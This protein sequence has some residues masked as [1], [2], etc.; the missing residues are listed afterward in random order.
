MKKLII[1]CLSLFMTFSLV[2]AGQ[3]NNS[4]FISGAT[5]APSATFSTVANSYSSY[6]SPS[7]TDVN[8]QNLVS[9]AIDHS[10]SVYQ[11]T[12]L[13]YT[14]NLRL[15]LEDASLSTTTQDIA[16]SVQYNPQKVTA[17]KD[18]HVYTFS[19]KVRIVVQILSIIN[20]A[21]G[22]A[23]S[24]PPDIFQVK[25]E[26]NIERYYPFTYASYPS[27]IAITPNTNAGVDYEYAV[28]WSAMT[29]A[30]EYEL[31]YT[32]A[33]TY[34]N[35]WNSF[36]ATGLSYNFRNNST[37]VRVSGTSYT[38]SNIFDKGRLVVRVRGIG[39]N[40]SDWSKQVFGA[41]SIAADS[42]LLTNLSNSSYDMYED[43]SRH[44]ETL[45]WQYSATFA[46]EG[47][48]KEIVSYF[49][50]SLRSRQMVTKSNTNN[51]VIVGESFYDYNGRKAVDALPVPTLDAN[52]AIKYYPSFNKNYSLAAYS[53][54]DF[55]L[56]DPLGNCASPTGP[57]HPSAGASNYYSTLNALNTATSDDRFNAY[58]PIAFD[59][60]LVRT[61]YTPDNTGRIRRQ[62]GV[63]PDHQLGTG[64]ET[65]YFYGKP[66]QFEL[67]R[68]FGSEAGYSRFYKKDMVIDPNGQVSISFKDLAGKVV[69]TALAGAVA[70]P[71]TAL[72][73]QSTSAVSVTADL[74]EKDGHGHSD[75]N[76]INQN[77][78]ALELNTTFL[79][80][81]SGTYAFDYSMSVPSYTNECMNAGVCF[82]CVYNLTIRITDDCGVVRSTRTVRVGPVLNTSCEYPT[83]DYTTTAT[84][85]S[86]T[87]EVGNYHIFKQLTVDES[88]VNHYLEEMMKEENSCF[89]TEEEFIQEEIALVDSTDCSMSC[90]EC[91]A[92]L[93]TRDEFVLKGLGSE[94]DWEL[95]YQNC[96]EP[97]SDLSKCQNFF[98][99]MLS[100][101]S[102]GG[103]YAEWYDT[104][105]GRMN[106]ATFPL[107]VFNENNYLTHTEV[108]LTSYN[109][110]WR[111]PLHYKWGVGYFNENG[112]PATIPVIE[113]SP[114][115]YY[116]PV[117][118]YST[119]PDGNL[120]ARPE[121]LQ[122]E[123]DFMLYWQTSWAQSLVTYH[124]EYCYYEWCEVNDTKLHLERSS[125]AFDNLLISVFYKSEAVT[126]GLYPSP[127]FTDLLD[128]DPY[129]AVGGRG[130]A[131]KN[132]MYRIL[133]SFDY[134]YSNFSIKQLAAFMARRPGYYAT[135]AP[136]SADTTFGGGSDTNV[137][138]QEWIHY[139]MLYL[140]E[141]QKL[142]ERAALEYVKA[143]CNKGVNS[144]IGREE[145]NY[146]DDGLPHTAMTNPDYIC[147]DLRSYLYIT[148][149][150]RFVGKRDVESTTKA[151]TEFALYY[152]TGICPEGIYL[153]T[154]L[155]EVTREGNLLGTFS[156]KDK[157]YFTRDMY[158]KVN[159]GISPSY[160]EYY[161][162]PAITARVLTIT[163]N[164][165]GVGPAACDI[166]L[167]LPTPYIF[168][169]I[170]GFKNIR[171]P[172]ISSNP[173]DFDITALYDH[174]FN[175][176]TPNI[177]IDLYGYSCFQLSGCTFPGVCDPNDLAKDLMRLFNVMIEAPGNDFTSTS[178]ISLD[179]AHTGFIT[180]EIE[181]FLHPLFLP[182]PPIPPTPPSPPDPFDVTALRYRF[183]STSGSFEFYT[184]THLGLINLN[185]TAFDPNTFTLTPGDLDKIIYFSKIEPDPFN[186]RGFYLVAYYD[187]DSDPLTDPRP[188]TIKATFDFDYLMDPG[189]HGGIPLFGNCRP[190]EPPLCKT[191]EHRTRKDLELF[192]SRIVQY[193]PSSTT[194][195]TG[196]SQWTSLLQGQLGVNNFHLSAPE[197]YF[198]SIV[199]EI[200]DKTVPT[201][202]RTVCKLKLYRI[203]PYFNNRYDFAGIQNV[204]SIVVDRN[205][206][207]DGKAY[208]FTILATHSNGVTERIAGYT[209]CLPVKDCDC[210]RPPSGG[211]GSG[212]GGGGG[213]IDCNARYKVF[214]KAVERFNEGGF[215][216]NPIPRITAVFVSEA[217]FDCDC[218]P[219]YVKY[220]MTWNSS[221]GPLKSMDE[222]CSNTI[223]ICK[224]TKF[225]ELSRA[226]AAFKLRHPEFS[227]LTND[228][229][230]GEMCDCIDQYIA[231]LNNYTGTSLPMTPV[232]FEQN[233]GCIDDEDCEQ[234]Y[235]YYRGSVMAFNG[236]PFRNPSGYVVP[237]ETID[238]SDG[239][240]ECLRAYSMYIR[241]QNLNPGDAAPM[242]FSAFK[243]GGYCNITGDTPTV[244]GGGDGGGDTPVI[245]A[246]GGE[247]MQMLMMPTESR[248]S[249]YLENSSIYTPVYYGSD[250]CARRGFESP[251]YD[252]VNRCAEHLIEV[253]KVNGKIRYQKYLEEFKA[254]QT[255]RYM[256]HCLSALTETFDLDYTDRTYHYTLYYYD[257][258]G[259]LIRT[260]PPAGVRL[261]SNAEVSAVVV[262]RTLKRKR[263][264]TDHKL[265]TKYEY[266][267]LNQLIKQSVPDHDMMDRWYVN[268]SNPAA[269]LPTNFIALTSYAVNSKT[270]FVAG[271]LNGFG[272]LY[273]SDD[274]GNNW[275]RV[276]GI[277]TSELMEIQM[278]NSTHGYAVGKDGLM[279]K[280]TDGGASWIIMPGAVGILSQLN[281]LYFRNANEG[282]VVGESGQ[283]WITSDGGDNWTASSASI[284]GSVSSITA[285]NSSDLLISVNNGGAGQ[286]YKSTNFGT[287]WTV[288][289]NYKASDL[290]DI[291]MYTTTGGFAAGKDGV[292]LKTT[293]GGANWTLVNTNVHLNFRR[294]HFRDVNKGMA[295][296]ESSTP[297]GYIYTTSNG[298]VTWTQASALGVYRDFHFY[299]A[300]EGY[301]VGNQNSKGIL[302]ALDANL[303]RVS[304]LKDREDLAINLFAVH[305]L[306]E[307]MGFVAG[308]NGKVFMTVNA[309][310]PYMVWTPVSLGAYA[311]ENIRD[312][313][314]NVSGNGFLITDD[315]DLLK[316]NSGTTTLVSGGSDNYIATADNGSDLFL[317]E[318]NSYGRVVKTPISTLSTSFTTVVTYTSGNN[319][320]TASGKALAPLSSGVVTVGN[321]GWTVSGSTLSENNVDPLEINDVHALLSSS[322]ALAVGKDGSVWR[323]ANA[324][325]N[326]SRTISGTSVDLNTA[327]LGSAGTGLVGG[328]QGVLLALSSGALNIVNSGTTEN[329]LD[330]DYL[331]SSN[332]A[333]S[334]TRGL[335][336]LS[337]NGGTSWSNAGTG[338]LLSIC[339]IQAVSYFASGQLLAVGTNGF[340]F[341]SNGTSA[342]RVTDYALP[343]PADMDFN[344]GRYGSLVG[345]K[346]MILTTESAGSVWKLMPPTVALPL[347]STVRTGEQVILISDNQN[348]IRRSVDKGT[349]F[350]IQH[351]GSQ[352]IRDMA[353][354]DADNGA[355]VGDNGTVLRT[356]NGGTSWTAASLSG[357]V[358][359]HLY[360]VHFAY[361]RGFAAGAGGRII[362]SLNGG[363]NWT[364]QTS[365]TTEDLRKIY[366]HDFHT[367]YVLGTNGTLLKS[368]DKGVTW[369]AKVNYNTNLGSSSSQTFY[370][371]AFNNRFDGFFAGNAYHRRLNDEADL[372]SSFFYYD[373]L[374][375]LVVSENTRQFNKTANVY[376]YN[377]FDAQGRIIETGEISQNGDVRNLY[378]SRQLDETLFTTWMSG[379]NS[380]KEVIQTYY[381][382]PL[383]GLSIPSFIQRN[384]RKRVATVS[385]E[386]VYDG[387]DLTYTNA[388]HYD[389]DVHGNVTKLV[390]DNPA[391]NTYGRR[392]VREDYDYDLVSGN[393]NNFIYQHGQKD[394]WIHKYS[395]DA[396]NRVIEVQTSRDNIIWDVDARYEYYR[397]GPLARTE[398]GDLKV[399]GMD[400]AYTLLGGIKGVN[401]NTLNP[402]E[403]MGKDGGSYAPHQ[404]VARDAFGYTVGY[405]HGDY[406]SVDGLSAGPGHFVPSLSGSGLLASRNNFYNGN[407]TSMTTSIVDPNSY[408]VLPQGRAFQYDQLNR[409]SQ[410]LAFSN[411]SL[412]NN[413][414]LS[415]GVNSAYQENFTYDANGNILTLDR[416]GAPG[417]LSMDLLS[418]K[419]DYFYNHP[420]SGMRSN[421]LY[422][423]DDAV[424]SS[425]TDDIDDQGTFTPHSLA[426]NVNLMNNYRFDETGNLIK[427]LAEEIDNI[428]WTVSG[429]IKKVT[430]VPG[431]TKSD[432]EFV[433]DA[434]GNRVAKIE[435]PKPLNPSTYRTTW[436]LHN[437]MG[438]SIATYEQHISVHNGQ[439]YLIAT[440]KNIYG[441]SRLG[442]Q[443]R[444]DTIYGPEDE[445]DLL[446][447]K[448]RILGTKKYEGTNHLGNVLAVFTD[449]KIPKDINAN[450]IIDYY[451]ADV[452]NSYDYYSFGSPMP[453][454][455]LQAYEVDCYWEASS[456]TTGWVSGGHLGTWTP[457]LGGTATF[458]PLYVRQ[459]IRINTPG[460]GARYYF[461]GVSPA[462][463]SPGVTITYNYSVN[464]TVETIYEGGTIEVFDISGTPMT[465]PQMVPFAGGP[466]NFSL[467]FTDNA[468]GPY[469]VRVTGNT[470]PPGTMITQ[471]LVTN[472][473][474]DPWLAIG[475]AFTMYDALNNRQDVTV[476]NPMDGSQYFFVTPS[477]GEQVT[478]TFMVQA[479]FNNVLVEVIPAGGPAMVVIVPA[480]MMMPI[481]HIYNSF[482]PNCLIRV[483]SQPTS[484]IYPDN[485]YVYNVNVIAQ[486][487][488]TWNDI[489]VTS[490][491]VTLNTQI[492]SLKCDTIW[493]KDYRFGF[494]GMEKDNE[495]KGMGNSL[496]LGARIYDSRL[497]RFFSIDPRIK[498]Y[499]WQSPYSYYKNTPISMI[500]FNG[501]GGEDS[502]NST[503]VESNQP[504]G[505]SAA[506]GKQQSAPSVAGAT[507][508]AVNNTS[509]TAGGTTAN[510]NTQTNNQGEAG[511]ALEN[512]TTCPENTPTQIDNTTPA[513]NSPASTVL[514]SQD[515]YK[516]QPAYLMVEGIGLLGTYSIKGTV[517][518]LQQ[519]N[520]KKII[521]VN[522]SGVIPPA[523]AAAGSVNFSGKAELIVD[524][525]VQKTYSFTPPSGTYFYETGTD[526]MGSTW[527]EMPTSGK[528]E[529]RITG[530]YNF[531]ANDGSGGGT[532]I[533]ATTSET[534]T[535]KVSQ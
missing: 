468:N 308:D 403:D 288:L 31:E 282:V 343:A 246:G 436:Y 311:A 414:F 362:T 368:V 124:P 83:V 243:A 461:T 444:N 379:A 395:Y 492:D 225:A 491:S 475:G 219:E 179:P 132:T 510:A 534:V 10:S 26:I 310:S 242:S 303:L 448:D 513:P 449:K 63:G 344:G 419:Y 440:E 427:D 28:N 265:I 191:A 453:G 408:A 37:R 326:W 364:I 150:K 313:F 89:K 275:F 112:Q 506:Q 283:V 473:Q 7:F 210:V 397:H 59:Y 402:N 93:G 98:R 206:L 483:T 72:N 338:T 136:P 389:Y 274:G 113:V 178:V 381:D 297:G 205:L 393:V 100:D 470:A 229:S 378:I 163:F 239:D 373:K 331:N 425:Y 227:S 529:V 43:V 533:P 418:Y 474:A 493:A 159:G 123:S 383:G 376:S 240:C 518:V 73:T 202:V 531:R 81:E 429:K 233:G 290:T 253:A 285:F 268:A 490:L 42:D 12:K 185:F 374:D 17:F 174:D 317:L 32:W 390:T 517:S 369:A 120:Y 160:T 372:F 53:K 254:N 305:F 271:T 1:A 520:G 226:I 251:Q 351:T 494:N 153:E 56:D 360:S 405:Y 421:R 334:G 129:F 352:I 277:Q 198:D 361:D 204:S 273:R 431:S 236:S 177:E 258:A 522:A 485:I 127:D 82:D 8:I 469:E 168:A 269:A 85:I 396:D 324:G 244:P 438:N 157:P 262:D 23:V 398:V 116:P 134:G 126:L 532:P 237:I 130:A 27:G 44:E 64:H 105:S 190:Q 199:Y 71:T 94:E 412:A 348:R 296:L 423:V 511:P 339:D 30:E 428:E 158:A 299:T 312:I 5:V 48:K 103:Q 525:V 499:S 503:P 391:L 91:V 257:Q 207:I 192:F 147:S 203:D 394:Q 38:I 21:T 51:E 76:R 79:V 62:G 256:E 95:A 280:T 111:N 451:E 128:K 484:M 452:L 195:L 186:T 19:G 212:G 309:T 133:S 222:Y 214:A 380:R 321:T 87:L 13:D 104:L 399:Q 382:K 535:I 137:H 60:P 337:S 209:S 523:A 447:Y 117:T 250:H 458:N 363:A 167:Q 495:M 144:C 270:T 433:Y 197:V 184:S 20:N 388:M 142:Q 96:I 57:L 228:I 182:I 332:V 295:I 193:P 252:V 255:K 80:S 430:R 155:N 446:Q 25:S 481:S 183:N 329:I 336:R 69:A 316:Y 432:L 455:T 34:T 463:P 500:D 318:N 467:A 141:K 39:R 413:E 298:G 460:D 125:E 335:F 107:S 180:S 497:G 41:W 434:M 40:P 278:V 454:R 220:L 11:G 68:L 392:Y 74:L 181:S 241:S 188:L 401:S 304:K 524:G 50:G 350:T 527:F 86:L 114:G 232:Q 345:A 248:E 131:Q 410:S 515:F 509:T 9:V 70:S 445:P 417:N 176:A 386:E 459:E 118:G 15:T 92:A 90:D 375:R 482:G 333:L 77:G 24:N 122:N 486:T 301:A 328:N 327:E 370:T 420:D 173:N 208:A 259:S 67:D 488:V 170:R 347:T 235:E 478:V 151:A 466:Q 154:L 508:N 165:I 357:T 156:L 387:N 172:Q 140:S 512:S 315:G 65:K 514:S 519:D 35:T 365:G 213:G 54:K 504:A 263:I 323:S 238:E 353:F 2:K 457:Y 471:P 75:M 161:Y 422:H 189:Y 162:S 101:M 272:Y 505:V 456:Q 146:F 18:K 266:N 143:N 465:S 320:S 99:M 223:E 47:K 196:I 472:G 216:N 106:T 314:F 416:N 55:D 217:E 476:N 84:P 187:H 261:L 148:K 415:G 462:S 479:G 231:Y 249:I 45:N 437:A 400:Y 102:P 302:A 443:D 110:Y 307:D 218:G 260:V 49:D 33:N 149:T 166:K 234:L 409:L 52:P 211:E 4:N 521:T 300:D 169:N 371:I 164:Q 496:N 119:D 115:V 439:N 293:D 138:N 516:T 6:P 349:S 22:S 121:Q 58:I 407:I 319:P 480:G 406:Y 286:L 267:S 66:L 284:T 3:S 139:V 404:K 294:V 384:L 264:F 355:A 291:S 276:E 29:G 464:V 201:N 289:N 435:K 489:Y 221:M 477:A 354:Y 215:G 325:T 14:F 175:P 441:S 487:P 194:S 507:T 501:E 502:Q 356:T 152:Q 306:D 342:S 108:G 279:Y 340:V 135:T 322:E 346:G 366:F 281:D 330:I 287:S 145:Y 377:L 359:N 200:M 450:N 411:F 528:V 78:N 46:E 426:T 385:Y 530:G 292:L 109:P 247:G 245:P 341:S 358:T 424:S 16:L 97:C 367:G 498:E 36:S 224:A 230:P 442:M 88:A 61:E 526:P 171:L